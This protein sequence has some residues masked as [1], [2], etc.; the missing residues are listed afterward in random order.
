[1]NK[2]LL[3]VIAAV[4]LLVLTVIVLR[5]SGG[6]QLVWSLSDGGRLLLPLVVVSALLDSINPCAFAILLITIAVLMGMGAARGRM[7]RVGG[8]YISG[9]FAAYLVIGLGIFGTLHLFDTPHFMGKVGAAVLVGWGIISIIGEIFPAFP[10][11]LRVPHAVH[12]RM[13][14]LMERATIPAAFGLGALV[15]L[16]EFPCTGG[17]YLMVLGLLHDSATYLRGIGYLVL[18]NGVFILPLVV[19]LMLAADAQVLAR[20]QAWRNANA[21]RMRIWG[22]AAMLALGV[23]IFFL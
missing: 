21:R 14:V 6:T 16:C 12:H 15:G 10:V 22:G 9:I 11:K 7:L 20:L 18:Y 3:I 23:A 1:M 8:V 4:I 5:S 19:L 17:P 13:A 2:R